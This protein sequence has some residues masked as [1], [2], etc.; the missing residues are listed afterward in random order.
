MNI[1]KFENECVLRLKLRKASRVNLCLSEW[2]PNNSTMLPYRLRA[3][4]TWTAIW[5]L[6][7]YNVPLQHYE[8]K[9]SFYHLNVAIDQT[10]TTGSVFVVL[11]IY[12]ASQCSVNRTH[13]TIEIFGS[14]LSLSLSVYLFFLFLYCCYLEQNEWREKTMR[15]HHRHNKRLGTTLDT[16]RTQKSHTESKSAWRIWNIRCKQKCTFPFQQ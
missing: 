16:R 8:P 1:S 14:P 5:S 4:K 11:R 10:R 2:L 6:L 13:W 15:V 7:R 9:L 3:A 12:C